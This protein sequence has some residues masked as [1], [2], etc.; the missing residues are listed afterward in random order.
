VI[1]GHP[2]LVASGARRVIR[3]IAPE[4]TM[5]VPEGGGVLVLVG[6]DQPAFDLND[7]SKPGTVTAYWY[8]DAGAGEEFLSNPWVAGYLS[9][10]IPVIAVFECRSDAEAVER[11]VKR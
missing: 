4:A 8:I 5:H 1:Q 9:N 2:A 10:R 7:L 11:R 6:P 3:Q